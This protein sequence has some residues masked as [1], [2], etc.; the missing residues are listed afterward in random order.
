MRFSRQGYWS[1]LPF[2]SP[3]DIPDPM[4]ENLGLLHHGQI[5]YL[6]SYGS[7]A[8]PTEK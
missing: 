2:P 1:G 5:L 7:K 3:R 8:M 6:L 4:I